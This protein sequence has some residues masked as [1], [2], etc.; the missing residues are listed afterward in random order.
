MLRIGG[1]LGCLFLL[2]GCDRGPALP[3]TLPVTGKVV[4]T[5]GGTV[6]TLADRQG[7]VEFESVDE[8]GMKAFGALQEDGTFTLTSVKDGGG[9][10]GAVP[11]TH[12][13][14]LYLDEGAARFVA[15]RFLTFET[16][17]ITVKVPSEQPIEIK[18]W[19]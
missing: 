12:R 10:E 7:M 15:P 11:G 8:P 18:V 16:S 14:R 9:K 3:S 13:V 4:Y 17:G 2:V 5:K 19:R 6:K 1:L